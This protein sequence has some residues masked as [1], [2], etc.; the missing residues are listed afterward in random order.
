MDC[1]QQ[2]VRHFA[3]R[4]LTRIAVQFTRAVVP[5]SDAVLCVAYQNRVDG[6]IQQACLFGQLFFDLLAL[7]NVVK[8]I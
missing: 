4:L 3:E 1:A 7:G 6:E 8:A 2:F 5:I